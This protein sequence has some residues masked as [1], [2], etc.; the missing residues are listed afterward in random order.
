MPFRTCTSSFFKFRNT[1]AQPARVTSFMLNHW[2]SGSEHCSI[3]PNLMPLDFFDVSPMRPQLTAKN[4]NLGEE[5]IFSAGAHRKDSAARWLRRWRLRKGFVNSRPASVKAGRREAERRT[6][7]LLGVRR[8]FG[9]TKTAAYQIA[10]R[11]R[12]VVYRRG[13]Q[14][15]L[16]ALRW[17][18]NTIACQ[19]ND[20]SA[21]GRCD[22]CGLGH[23]FALRWPS[24][25]FSIPPPSLQSAGCLR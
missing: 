4:S 8:R 1:N 9:S 14:R 13:W 25:P 22:P 11:N 16:L 2:P 7:G 5:R 3:G 23:A 12:T 19:K 21:H 10:V 24:A 15:N 18:R 17:H 20:F 6:Y